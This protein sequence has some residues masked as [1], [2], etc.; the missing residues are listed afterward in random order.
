[1]TNY[2]YS[3]YTEDGVTESVTWYLD[4]ETYTATRDHKN[5]VS[6]LNAVRRGDNKD[7]ILRL[8]SNKTRVN[9][10]FNRVGLYGVHFDG[11]SIWVNGKQVPTELSSLI[12]NHVNEGTNPTYLVTFFNK[13]LNNPSFQSQKELVAFIQRHDLTITKTGNFIAYKGLTRDGK[14]IHSGRATVNGQVVSG[15]IPNNVGST[16]SMPRPEVDDNRDVAC[17]QGLHAGTWRYANGF[18]RN[19]TCRVEIDPADVVSVPKDSDE[20][21]LRVCKYTVVEAD[22]KQPS[23]T[24]VWSNDEDSGNVTTTSGNTLWQSAAV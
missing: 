10:Y 24:L 13:L 16:I 14:S 11:G 8:F 18:G 20:Q 23:N 21:K 19:N 5:F 12:I 9:D 22:L 6:I 2:T 3:T 1:M 17:S 4:D 7:R 15:Q